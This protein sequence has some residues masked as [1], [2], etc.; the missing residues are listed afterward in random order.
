MINN[1]KEDNFITVTVEKIKRAEDLPAMKE[2]FPMKTVFLRSPEKMPSY[3]RY[4]KACEKILIYLMLVI[5]AVGFFI[6]HLISTNLI[7]ADLTLI[8][9]LLIFFMLYSISCEDSN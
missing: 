4:S 9:L 5:V 8:A 6:L 1:V 2:M 7:V 3:E